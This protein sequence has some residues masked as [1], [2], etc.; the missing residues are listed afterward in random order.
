MRKFLL[1]LLALVVY[2]FHFHPNMDFHCLK[3]FLLF[4]DDIS[5]E[6]IEIF[7]NEILENTLKYT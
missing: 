1:A 3:N 7:L 2:F 5:L 6:E 4:F